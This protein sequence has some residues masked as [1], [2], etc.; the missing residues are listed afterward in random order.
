MTTVSEQLTASTVTA[1]TVDGP[2][3][4]RRLWQYRVVDGR[5]HVHLHRC[6]PPREDGHLR[7]APCG[8]TYLIVVGDAA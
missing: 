1:V 3:P 6:G 5:G 7:T 2:C 4:G 8:L